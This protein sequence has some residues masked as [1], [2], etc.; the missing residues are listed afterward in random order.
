M[1][2]GSTFA[3]W[4]VAER[5]GLS[6]ILTIVVYAIVIARTAPLFMPARLRVPSLA[7]WETAVFILKAFAFVLIGLQIRPI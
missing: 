7:F 6:G 2:F 5:I 4:I 1:Q 3:I